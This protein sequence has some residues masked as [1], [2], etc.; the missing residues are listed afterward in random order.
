ML[1]FIGRRYQAQ[2]GS[3]GPQDQAQ[4]S[5]H[6]HGS[7]CEGTFIFGSIATS[8]FV[9]K[10]MQTGGLRVQNKCCERCILIF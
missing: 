3:Q 8:H 7:T 6:L 5:G 4:V 2:K 1:H 10:L 9:M